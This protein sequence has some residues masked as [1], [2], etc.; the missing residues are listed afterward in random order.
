MFAKSALPPFFSMARA[1]NFANRVFSESALSEAEKT[2]KRDGSG[3]LVCSF[4]G[5]TA[6]PYNFQQPRWDVF[7]RCRGFL[8][9]HARL[10][11]ASGNP[12]TGP[13]RFLTHAAALPRCQSGRLWNTGVPLQQPAFQCALILRCL[14]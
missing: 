13:T 11:A 9:R 6:T 1:A 3:F 4:K 14:S 2:R 12:N 10:Y 8:L 7:L 5:I